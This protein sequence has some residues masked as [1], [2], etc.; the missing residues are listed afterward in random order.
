MS[1][2]VVTPD[3]LSAA[4]ADLDG[5]GAALSAGT[6]A[7]APAMTGVMAAAQDEV[8]IAMAALFGQHANEY[9]VL[10]AQAESVRDHFVRTLSGAGGAYFGAEAASVA[11]LQALEEG[12]LA[13][14][15]APTLALLGRPLIGDGANATIPGAP[16][17]PAGC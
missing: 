4:A 13:V 14:V 8:S 17:G 15:N 12:V 16:A 9:Q 5:I 7:A 10:A 3:T 1:F 11:P 6:A 2:L